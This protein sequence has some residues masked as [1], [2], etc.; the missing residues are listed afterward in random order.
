MSNATFTAQ[1]AKTFLD[2]GKASGQLGFM[3]AELA[4]EMTL[5][6]FLPEIEHVSISRRTLD[7]KDG[8]VFDIRFGAWA[9]HGFYASIQDKRA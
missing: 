7:F 2:E 8:S 9:K 4:F 6:K 3:T 1:D 5:N